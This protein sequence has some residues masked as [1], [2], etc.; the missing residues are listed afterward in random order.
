MIEKL[1]RKHK[2]STT[3]HDIDLFKGVRKDTIRKEPETL[4]W[5]DQI[6][7]KDSIFYDIGANVGIFTLVASKNKNIKGIYSFEPLFS[8]FYALS[9][10][11]IINKADQVSAFNIALSNR[12]EITNLNCHSIDFGAALNGIIDNKNYKGQEFKVNN[13][14]PVQSYCLNF[15]VDTFKLPKPT[16]LKI[17][18]DGKE[19]NVVKGVS[20]LFKTCHEILIEVCEDYHYSEITSYIEKYGF[21]KHKEFKHSKSNNIIYKR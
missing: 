15:F 19:L 21:K 11:I 14:I 18:V 8:N 4:D 5:I 10:N 7:Q 16:H 1:N 20:D 17:D 12:N 3:S 9:Q 2:G 13:V 6:N